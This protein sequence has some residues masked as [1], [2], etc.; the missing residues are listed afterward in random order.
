LVP[1]LWTDGSIGA[2]STAGLATGSLKL[3]SGNSDKVAYVAREVQTGSDGFALAPQSSFGK[4]NFVHQP[5]HYFLLLD[6]KFKFTVK[7]D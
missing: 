6:P 4:F 2:I 1:L 7:K 5:T 3:Y